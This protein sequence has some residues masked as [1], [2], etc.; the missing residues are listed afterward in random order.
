M[1]A[2]DMGSGF[3]GVGAAWAGGRS[4]FTASKKRLANTTL[5][6]VMFDYPFLFGVGGARHSVVYASPIHL[7]DQMMGDLTFLG[8]VGPDGDHGTMVVEELW[9]KRAPRT[10][11]VRP[12][13]TGRCVE[14]R[15]R[16]GGEGK[17]MAKVIFGYS[18]S[19]DIPLA[20]MIKTMEGL[21]IVLVT[22]DVPGVEGDIGHVS[23]EFAGK[24]K[25]VVVNLLVGECMGPENL[26]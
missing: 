7:I 24:A 18:I 20:P 2:H 15:G 3:G 16:R 13:L 5:V 8:P 14:I 1:A 10:L 22:F 17:E 21:G 25:K 11:G 9:P 6:Q 12:E 19:T 26:A 4:A 23:E